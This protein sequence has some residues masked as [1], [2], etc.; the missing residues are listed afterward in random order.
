MVAFGGED[1]GA[2]AVGGRLISGV[3]QMKRARVRA[4]VPMSMRFR[5]GIFEGGDA[6]GEEAGVAV[7]RRRRSVRRGCLRRV[8]ADSQ[9]VRRRGEAAV[10]VACVGMGIVVR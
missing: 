6:V 3:P 7:G 5:A 4:G 1:F 10:H 9:L 2:D 8:A